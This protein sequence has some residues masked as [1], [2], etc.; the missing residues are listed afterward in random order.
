MRILLE[1]KLCLTERFCLTIQTIAQQLSYNAGGREV[2]T[3]TKLLYA[4]EAR[5]LAERKT[6]LSFVAV[7]AQRHSQT[8]RNSEARM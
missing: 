3:L 4:P 7:P 2:I 5:Q 6:I 1:V 8:G